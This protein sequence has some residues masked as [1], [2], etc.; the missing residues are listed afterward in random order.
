MSNNENLVR[1]SDV[2]DI[3]NNSGLNASDYEMYSRLFDEIDSMTPIK[4]IEMPC[5]VGDTV[6]AFIRD[7]MLTEL[8]GVQ[9]VHVSKVAVDYDGSFIVSGEIDGDNWVSTE[10]TQDMQLDYDCFLN[11]EDAEDL[12]KRFK[13]HEP[14]L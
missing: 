7:A 10:Y 4:A 2:L 1:I 14:E 5:K 12:A 6:Y 3:L 11:R 13:P 9:P 8:N